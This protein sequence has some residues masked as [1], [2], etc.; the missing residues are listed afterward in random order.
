[1]GAW[2]ETTEERKLREPVDVAPPVG[3]WIETPVELNPFGA[4]QSRPPWA[5][6]LKHIFDWRKRY[7][8]GRA[9]RGRVD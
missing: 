2:I 7:C 5:R 4:V 8:F 6:G 9:P 1:M 3:A